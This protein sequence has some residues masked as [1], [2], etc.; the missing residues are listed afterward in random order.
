MKKVKMKK[1]E[2]ED[3]LLEKLIFSHSVMMAMKLLKSIILCIYI[4]RKASAAL[5]C[6]LLVSSLFLCES[7][8]V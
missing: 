1:N 7:K 6:F 2:V 5:F 8:T 3:K 4:T